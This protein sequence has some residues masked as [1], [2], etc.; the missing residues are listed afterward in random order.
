MKKSKYFCIIIIA[1]CLIVIP[2]KYT[3]AV[4]NNIQT[5]QFKEDNLYKAVKQQLSDKIITNDDTTYTIKIDSNQLTQITSLKLN[6][7]KITNIAGIDKFTNLKYLNLSNNNITNM[8]ALSNLTKLKSLD[9]YGCSISDISPLNTLTNLENLNISRNKL[10][11]STTSSDNAISKISNLNKLK[12]LNMSHNGLRTTQGIGNFTNLTDLDLYDNL[13]SDLNEIENLTK[14]QNLNLGENNERNKWK[15]QNV[16]SLNSLTQLKKFNFSQ[17][18]T[19]NIIGYINKLDNLEELQLEGNRIKDISELE[20]LVNLKSLN[21]YNN[22][23]TEIQSLTKLINLQEIILQKNNINNISCIYQ[24]SNIV[25]PQIQ[26]IDLAYNNIEKDSAIEYLCQKSSEKMIEF[27]Y[28]YISNTTNLPHY[29]TNGVAYVTYEDFGARC[30][31]EYDDFIAIRNAH[32][33]ANNNKCEVRA[34][35]GKIYHIFK[36]YEEPIVVKTNINWNNAQFII[37]DEKIEGY[38]GRDKNISKINNMVDEDIITINEVSWTIDKNTKK[39]NGIQSELES[40]NSKGYSKYLCVAQNSNKKQYIRYGNN[41]NSGDN[42]QDYFII[43]SEE[44]V[45]NDIQWDFETITDFT[46]YPIPNSEL[47]IKNGNFITNALDGENEITYTKR[48]GGKIAYLARNICVYQSSNVK[49]SNINHTLTKDTLSGSYAGFIYTRI[50]TDIE[51]TNMQLF[52]RKHGLAGRSTYDL[53]IYGTVNITCQNITSND[54][55]N[56]SRW[57]IVATYFSKD[58]TFE[59][60]VLNRIDAHQ[61]IYNLGIYNCEIGIKG[62]T[63]TGQGTLNVSGTTIKAP[64]FITLRKDYGSTWN[65]DVNIEDCTYVYNGKYSPKIFSYAFSYDD[66]KLHDFGYECKFPNVNIN[67]LTVDNEN[68]TKYKYVLII[69]NNKNSVSTEATEQNKD[70]W[71]QSI[72][73]NGCGF[74]NNK[75]ENP[76]VKITADKLEYLQNSNIVITNVAFDNFKKEENFKTNQNVTIKIN[77]INNSTNSISITR[78]DDEVLVNKTL[79]KDFKYTFKDNGKYKII[80]SS[81]ENTYGYTGK[82]EYSFEIDKGIQTIFELKKYQIQGEYIIKIKPKTKCSDFIKSINTNQKYIIKEADTEISENDFI[83]T[84]QTL[85]TED[86]KIYILIVIG[87]LNGSGKIGVL[88]L[89]RISKIGAGIEKNIKEIERMAIDANGDGQINIIDLAAISKLATE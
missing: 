39:I 22:R 75:I 10:N 47:N 68:N 66:D 64:I 25:W 69:P 29:D 7:E 4:E 17:N 13:I 23:I 79:S 74:I 3:I 5:I 56:D 34:T 83:K 61:G 58:V 36:Y 18:N 59:N 88:E 9:I 6:N 87:D 77:K 45:K 26:K 32:I 76:Y 86:G 11:D 46:I 33:F 73:V 49:L 78:L 51:L 52:A 2:K 38:S 65:G 37:H 21:L 40:L 70:Y 53:N 31:G 71:P 1:I 12:T 60:C 14:L 24:D 19:S 41:S 44:N 48:G 63:L 54:I 27:N 50:C 15:I 28:E 82:E 42:Q 35:K 80:L 85:I 55:L 57:G 20:K 62:L 84:G 67:N 72:R 43:D 30:D 16:N 89:A 8:D 81:T